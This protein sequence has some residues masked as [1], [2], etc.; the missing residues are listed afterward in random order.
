MTVVTYTSKN[1]IIAAMGMAGLVALLAMPQAG[2][3][4]PARELIRARNLSVLPKESGCLAIIGRSRHMVTVDG[5]SLAV[6]SQNYY[7]LT[8]DRPINYLHWL[9]PDDTHILIEGGPVDY[10]IFIRVG[11]R[12]KLPLGWTSLP[13]RRRSSRWPVVAGGHSGSTMA[14]VMH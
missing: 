6:Q 7:M 14:P 5:R 1:L 3:D 4:A 9:A 2:S 12:R 10:F 8:R 11:A 13:A